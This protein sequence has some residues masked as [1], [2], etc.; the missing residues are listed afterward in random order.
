MVILQHIHLTVLFLTISRP[1]DFGQNPTNPWL[2]LVEG[3]LVA[4]IIV[5][6]T[7]QL[8]LSVLFLMYSS[9]ISRTM[10][11]LEWAHFSTAYRP[12][13]VT[14]PSGDQVSTYFL[15][16]PY[17]YGIPLLI[18]S[19]VLHW[20]VSQSLYA[21]VAE[22]GELPSPSHGASPHMSLTPRYRLDIPYRQHT[23]P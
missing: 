14:Q 9:A 16:I 2:S 11:G 23:R 4:S 6:N 13:R 15:Q 10:L 20:L 19:V 21:V 12:L 17:R 1:N 18:A 3:R 8:I 22:G 7:P 5:A